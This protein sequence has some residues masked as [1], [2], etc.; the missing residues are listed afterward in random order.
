[1]DVYT[2]GNRRERAQAGK[3]GHYRRD[4]EQ[5]GAGSVDSRRA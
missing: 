1:L 3:C 4:D 5:T 2:P